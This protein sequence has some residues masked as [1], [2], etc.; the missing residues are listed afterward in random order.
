[1]E[2]T[3]LDDY[4]VT[5]VPMP[6]GGLVPVLDGK[7]IAFTVMTYFKDLKTKGFGM[8]V[9]G[10]T[11]GALSYFKVK[12]RAT[13]SLVKGVNRE[14]RCQTRE[15]HLG[16]VTAI[17]YCT[18]PLLRSDLPLG[19][20]F[21]ASIDRTIKS[22]MI[23][24]GLDNPEMCL[25]TMSGHANNVTALLETGTGA[26][27]SC[28]SDCTARVWRPQPGGSPGVFICTHAIAVQGQGGLTSLALS[29]GVQ[30]Q[31]LCYFFAG[32]ADG[33]I[34]QCQAVKEPV[35]GAE[36][37][38]VASW[39]RVHSLGVSG[40]LLVRKLDMLVS[41]SYDCTCVVLNSGT[42]A[43][44]FK[45]SN[46]H[47]RFTGLVWD[48]IHDNVLLTDMGGSITA[49][50][51]YLKKVVH[52]TPLVEPFDANS[53]LVARFGAAAREAAR[54]FEPLLGLAWLHGPALCVAQPQRARLRSYRV[55]REAEQVEYRG[56]NGPI[57]GLLSIQGSGKAPEGKDAE[58]PAKARDGRP[59]GERLVASAS[60][61]N[62][63]RFWEC[64]DEAGERLQMSEKARGNKSE[65]SCLISLPSQKLLVTGNTDGSITWYA[66]GS[67]APFF[68]FC[69]YFQRPLCCDVGVL[70]PPARPRWHQ[71]SG[72]VARRREHKNTVTALAAVTALR[73]AAQEEY[74][75]SASFDGS[76]VAW[77]LAEAGRFAP[78]VLQRVAP[79][80][81]PGRPAE[82]HC[83]AFHAAH[84]LVVSGASDGAL[85]CRRA[86]D[87]TV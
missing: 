81:L 82:I 12:E 57:V 60:V 19:I 4:T 62:T 1:M 15:P 64:G 31:R 72:A 45:I 30:G 35:A 83:L 87:R 24:S 65:I 21:T 13:P 70:I 9:A 43:L 52:R 75:L 27:V 34:S 63:L 71:D 74:L 50:S 11:D 51:G 39:P 61:D 22:W 33:S 18:D 40:L 86:A 59:S 54:S 26:L 16:R 80:A 79:S 69:V 58:E 41:I 25:H 68:S 17:L 47:H 66:L 28:S 14:V 7:P 20:L 46:P 23:Y 53:P 73:G 56:H 32:G 77:L 55:S 6:L 85:V 8:L 67:L 3:E 48:P 49:Y 78:H 37:H 5:S 42:G 29:P 2:F 38:L 84:Q 36:F 10:R 44:T 76:L